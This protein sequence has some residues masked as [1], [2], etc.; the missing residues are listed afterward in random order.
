M[1]EPFFNEISVNP[2][3]KTDQEVDKRVSDFVEVLEFCGSFLG[4]K[5]V[6]IDKSAKEIELKKDYY[7]K[8]YLAKNAYGN[9]NGAL[10][11]L[12]MLQPPNIDDGTVEWMRYAT[13]TA[14]L[15]RDEKEVE[16]E[17]FACAYY[18]SG[19]VVGFASEDFW[20]NNVSFTVSVKDDETGKS[21]K[22]RVYGIS[23]V[24]QFSDPGFITWAV[25][26]LPLKFRPSN[27]TIDTKK[28]SLR[29]DHGK[30]KL[31]ELSQ[32]LK[33]EQYV[34]EIVN[35]LPFKRGIHKKTD[36]TGDGILE[37]R[38]LDEKNKI[39][40]AVRTTARNELEAAY[41][42]RAIEKKYL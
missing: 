36:W 25:D 35:S 2:L 7:L 15:I 5:K 23:R 27:L 42:C 40:V 29:D 3:C 24:E 17:G 21:Q 11:V 32:K 16:A 19:F 12:N 30:D 41:L 9:N 22:H 14:R 34:A 8:D 20:T 13:H 39:G 26:T 4:F 33:K 18:S 28:V 38:L 1:H 31:M 37:V 10:L 6:R